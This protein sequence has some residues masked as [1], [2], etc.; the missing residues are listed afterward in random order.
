MVPVLYPSWTVGV[1]R[2]QGNARHNPKLVE[3]VIDQVAIDRCLAGALSPDELTKDERKEAFRQAY[4]I[5]V[6]QRQIQQDPN[7]WSEPV[8]RATS[9]FAGL[10][11]WRF[12]SDYL[13]L[14][15]A[16]MRRALAERPV[17]VDYRNSPIPYVLAAPAMAV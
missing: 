13:G 14:S 11:A 12:G 2:R 10:S 6:E 5:S 7:D 1:I 9:I 8:V 17:D 3:V 15:G 16:S 4:E